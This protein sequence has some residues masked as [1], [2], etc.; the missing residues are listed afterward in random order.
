LKNLKGLAIFVNFWKRVSK[1][2]GNLF[3]NSTRLC[4]APKRKKVD[5][6]A[7]DDVIEEAYSYSQICEGEFQ[8]IISA[9]WFTQQSKENEA[10]TLDGN[11]FLRFKIVWSFF[12]FL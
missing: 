8:K 6:N 9:F 5:V 1:D 4:E 10:I 3:K 2:K 7:K 11:L 12:D